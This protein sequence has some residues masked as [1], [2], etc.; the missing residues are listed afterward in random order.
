MV[1]V[2][3]VR[4]AVLGESD[5]ARTTGVGANVVEATTWSIEPF[6]IDRHPFPGPARPWPTRVPEAS[7]SYGE[8]QD[9]GELLPGFGRRL[10]RWSEVLLASTGAHNRRYPWGDEFE[11]RCEPDQVTPTRP[12]GGFPD[13]RTP[14]GLFDF[15]V[16]PS[17]ATL[18]PTTAR[19]LSDRGGASVLPGDLALTGAHG[20]NEA[21]FATSN[22]GIH[23]HVNR[24]GVF[25]A[26]SFPGDEW[27]DDGL[28]LCADP[29]A[30]REVRDSAWAAAAG[31]YSETEDWAAIW[32]APVVGPAKP[33]GWSRRRQR[34]RSVEAGRFSTCALDESGSA[35]CWGHSAVRTA[36]PTPG[37]FAALAVGWRHA[38]GLRTDGALAC[39][40]GHEL[41]LPE[42]PAGHYVEVAVGPLHGC[43]LDD[44]EKLWCWGAAPELPP[45]SGL[46]GAS[47]EADYGCGVTVAGAPVCWGEGPLAQAA[48]PQVGMLQVSAGPGHVCGVTSEHR[49]VCWGDDGPRSRPPAGLEG[50]K[51]V[52]V[53][54]LHT[55]ALTLDGALSCWGDDPGGASS[56]PVRGGP[57]KDLTSGHFHSCALNRAGRIACWG[58]DLFGQATPPR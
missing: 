25:G 8:A 29:G 30:D 32:G 15:G 50:V 2:P 14:E 5:T 34:F 38:C 48:P 11:A 36:T 35:T 46:L 22:F 9:V 54:Y 17:W 41:G 49:V 13:C 51:E 20:R 19:L 31:R 6:C 52:A 58:S 37:P 45:H 57:W 56:P 27:I 18:D 40:G 43:G 47:F 12:I 33:V 16:R 21:F 1:F 28:R 39:W 53:G 10:C 44:F 42:P 55:C 23:C 7:L 4:D 3:G 26:E 24:C